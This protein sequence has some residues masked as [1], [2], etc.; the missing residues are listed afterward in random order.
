MLFTLENNKKIATLIELFKVIKALNNFCKIYCNSDELFIQ[1]MDDAHVSLLEVKIKKEWFSTYES[2]DEV[3]SFNSK[4]LTTIM[5]LHTLDSIVTFETTTEYINITFEQKDKTEKS[6]QINL[7]ELDGV[8]IES[9]EIEH[10]LEFSINARKLDQ[11]FNELQSF[12]DTLELIHINDT[13]YMRSY[14]DE[15]KYMLK[16]TDDLLDDL[17]VEEDLQLMCKV[18]LKYTSLVTK[19]YSVFKKITVNT[20]EDAP[21][22]LKIF[23]FE[24][25]QKDQLEIKFF[26]APKVDDESDFDFSEFK[27]N[28][29]KSSG[30]IEKDLN[31]YKNEIIGS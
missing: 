17:I 7:I 6:F 9:Q 16:I 13:I 8:I 4:I 29:Q 25:E 30:I 28:N 24:D 15:G 18:P 31:D 20:S 3:V 11:Y 14:G 10:S 26:I 5:A 1:I 27:E 19:L 12:G 23:P 22:T 2:E 21:F